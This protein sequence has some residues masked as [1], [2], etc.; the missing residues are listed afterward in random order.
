[1][2]S[3]KKPKC[4]LADAMEKLAPMGTEPQPAPTRSPSPKP[5][6]LPP[7]ARLSPSEL[8]SLRSEMQRSSE[9]MRRELQKG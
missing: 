8:E 3:I 1:M 5:D 6:T 9:W 7:I 4:E 2:N